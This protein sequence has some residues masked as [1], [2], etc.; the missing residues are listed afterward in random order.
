MMKTLMGMVEYVTGIVMDD[1]GSVTAKGSK[2]D[3]DEGHELDANAGWHLG[4]YSRPLD[5]AVGFVVKPG[6]H[7]GGSILIAWR[8]RQYELSLEKGDTAM[9]NGDGSAYVKINNAGKIEVVPKS[10]QTA[11]INGEDYS[12]LKTET[13]LSDLN[14]LCTHL[15]A[16]VPLVVTAVSTAPSGTAVDPGVASTAGTIVTGIGAGTYKSTK[17]KNG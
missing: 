7:G 1:D 4:F 13:L 15:V 6:G 9:T 5:G 2:S 12:L 3:D 10:G 17:A 8:D 16:W 11:T 14:T